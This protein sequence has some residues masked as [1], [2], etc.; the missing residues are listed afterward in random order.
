MKTKWKE[1]PWWCIY[2]KMFSQEGKQNEWYFFLLCMFDIAHDWIFI[3]KS[4][5]NLPSLGTDLI[6]GTRSLAWLDSSH[7]LYDHS[8]LLYA[9]LSVSW[10]QFFPFLPTAPCYDSHN[11]LLPFDCEHITKSLGWGM[12]LRLYPTQPCTTFL[13]LPTSFTSQALLFPTRRNLK[14][15]SMGKQQSKSSGAKSSGCFQALTQAPYATTNYIRRLD[16][17]AHGASHAWYFFLIMLIFFFPLKAAFSQTLNQ[18]K[19]NPSLKT[20]VRSNFKEATPEHFSPQISQHIH[21]KQV[22]YLQ[23][24]P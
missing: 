13:F 2:W 9:G 23:S 7:K 10:L 19:S 15:K 16:L 14:P 21:T 6:L 8:K 12:G 17:T 4:S 20:Q 1:W 5:Y 3:I 22:L 11:S 24:V 18:F